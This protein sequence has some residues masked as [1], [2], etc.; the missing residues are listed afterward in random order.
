MSFRILGEHTAWQ[1]RRISAATVDVEAPGGETFSREIV[2][3][4]GAV[5]MVPV[6]DDGTVTL[7]HQFRAA[8]GTSMWEIPAGLRDIDGEAPEETARRELAEE[9]GLLSERLEH[10][11]TFHNSPGF[12]DESVVVYLATGLTEVPDDRQG[13]EERHMEVDRVPFG[14]ALAMLDDGRITD[15]KT[16]IGL[17]MLARRGA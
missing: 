5:A 10:L 4:P 14:T 7:V 12:S 15:A 3:H 9:T 16:V 11:L 2:R 6:H 1:G 13:V 17:L 8:I